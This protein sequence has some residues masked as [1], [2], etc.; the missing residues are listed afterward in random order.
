MT[1]ARQ[2]NRS[3]LRLGLRKGVLYYK[4]SLRRSTLG[5]Y[6]HFTGSRAEH[7]LRN[8]LF[9]QSLCSIRGPS[10]KWMPSGAGVPSWDCP[11]RQ[12]GGSRLVFRPSSQS[13]RALAKVAFLFHTVF[14]SSERFKCS[15]NTSHG[16]PVH[17]RFEYRGHCT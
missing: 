1:M 6:I 13:V 12:A 9:P 17:V 11:A 7:S 16:V 14:D 3:G 10:P 8:I 2:H 4:T 15:V 5:P